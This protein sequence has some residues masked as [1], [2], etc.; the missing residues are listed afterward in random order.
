MSKAICKSFTLTIK[1][2]IVLF[3][4]VPNEYGFR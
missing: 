2:D 1:I 3:F 4:S